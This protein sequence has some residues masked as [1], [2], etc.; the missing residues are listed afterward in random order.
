MDHEILLL[1][2]IVEHAT[3]GIVLLK[4][5]G[6]VHYVNLLAQQMLGCHR[7]DLIGKPLTEYVSEMSGEVSWEELL[8]RILNDRQ[9]QAR[10]LLQSGKKEAIICKLDY[11]HVGIDGNQQEHIALIFRDITSDLRLAEQL[12]KK[13]LETA[14][15]NSELIRSNSEL[16]R[17]SELKSNFLS[18]ASHELKTPLTSIK[19][20]SDIIIDNMQDKLDSG[21]YRMV[22][23]INRAADRLHKVVNNILDV[24]RIEQKRLRLKPEMLE[25]GA[26]ANDC[27]DELSQFSLKRNIVFHCDFPESLPNFYGD[28]MRMQQVFTNLFS[29][30][31]KYSPDGSIVEVKI[32][33]ENHDLFHI[34]VKDHGIGI[35]KSE[36]KNIFDPFYEVGSANRHSTDYAKFMGGGT[37]LGL[38]IVKGIIDRHGGKIW[39][40]SEG[41]K[42]NA[43]PGSAF[44]IILPMQ[45]E[46]SWD[47]DETKAIILDRVE[48][49]VVEVDDKIDRKPTILFIDSD[50]EAVEIARMVLENA[51]EIF[52]AETGEEGLRLAFQ[53]YPSVIL[54]DS[55]LPGLDGY[56]ICR[57]LRSQEETRETPIV[58]FSAGTQNDEIQMCFANGA[59]DFIVKPF[60][61]RELV[62]KI[63]RLLMK[64]KEEATFK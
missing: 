31:I 8:K 30:A 38:S 40:E 14:K 23:S 10:V 24:T 12:E 44:H 25:L 27:I 53:H 22:E 39:V 58:F 42:E 21:I 19:G 35:D 13:N 59:D 46:I 45:S 55:Y 47:D 20:Y 43:F 17:V 41:V 2:R 6:T 5:D 29:N 52:V 64:K 56:R 37:G 48:N 11:F 3:V 7:E 18:I 16:K 33:V 28:R 49:T 50:R 57:I 1:A 34:I 9:G 26:V 15:M 51:F 63:W 54:M 36:Q 32:F 62:D 61:G 60:N 4:A